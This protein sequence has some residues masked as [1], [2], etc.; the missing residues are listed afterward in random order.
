[1]EQ[2]NEFSFQARIM[3]GSGSQGCN[4]TFSEEDIILTASHCFAV[5]SKCCGSE[6]VKKK[7]R[8]WKKN[9]DP[10]YV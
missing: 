5:K 2:N 10:I 8:D 7:S 4:V 6:T 3:R 9:K 1:V